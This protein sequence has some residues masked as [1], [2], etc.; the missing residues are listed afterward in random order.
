LAKKTLQFD[1]LDHFQSM[2]I[3]NLQGFASQ[4]K[5]M[6]AFIKVM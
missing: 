4:K 2:G 1:H 5:V 3:K 6:S